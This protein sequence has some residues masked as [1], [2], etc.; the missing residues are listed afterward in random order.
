M[1]IR[2][3]DLFVA[4][5]R[6][7]LSTPCRAEATRRR[8]NSMPRR[9]RVKA[10][11]RL[12]K[13][14]CLLA[15][16]LLS[17]LNLQPSTFAQG[18]A[19]TYQ[20]QLQNNGSPASGTY[21]LTFSLFNVN[22]GGTAVAGP[23]TNNAVSVTNGLFTVLIDFGPGVFTG[24][25]NW[26]EIGVATNGVSSF[27]TLAPRQ[28]LTPT[29]YA[30][31][32][33]NVNAAGIS[34]TVPNASLSG[35]Y[36]NAVTLNNAGNNFS[37]NGAGLA[38]VNAAAL[39]GL[40]ATNYWQLG[41]NNVAAGQF[42]G[43]TNNQAVEFR[44]G[45]QR[46]LLLV[47][48]TTDAPNIIGGAT[49]NAVDA[50]VQGA[51]IAGGGTT[52][53]FGSSSPN[54]ISSDFSSI[55]G[56]SGNWIQNSANHS[57]IAGGLNN[58]I[59]AN[60][61]DSAIGGGL[62]N[63]IQPNAQFAFIGGGA[64][65]SIQDLSYES[66]LGGGA[67]NTIFSFSSRCFLGGGA[68]N[69]IRAGDSFLGGG[70]ANT[71]QFTADHSFLGGGLFNTNSG[72]YS[73]I[74]GGDYNLAGGSRSFAAGHRAKAVH[75]GT[76]VW[77][78]LTESD[79]Q[80]TGTNQF[81]IRAQGGLQLDN[82]TSQFFGNQ[83]RQMLN[84]YN[85]DYG[86]GV[87]T[88]T[89]YFR[90]DNS[91]PGTGF[92]WYLG[93]SHTDAQTNAGDGSTLMLL[94]N[95][96]LTVNG[97]VTASNFTGNGAGLTGVNASS[98][99]SGTLADARLSS[100]VAL[101]NGTQTFSGTNTFAGLMNFGNTTRQMLNLFTTLYGIGVQGY[102][103]YFRTDPSG[104][105]AWYQ[106]GTHN[107]G[108]NNPGGGKTLMLLDGSGNLIV[109]NNIYAHGVLLTSDRNTKE[110]FAP[111]D[112]C[113]VLDKVA[114]L[115]LSEWNFKGDSNT[116]HIGPM[117]QDF[118]A[119]FKVGED[120]KHIAVVDEGG[121]ALAAIQGLNQKLEETRAENADLKQRLAALEKIVLNQ[122]S[123]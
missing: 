118:K 82:S 58:A 121:V 47:P 19:F 71:I 49:V 6:L 68:G 79:F 35:T 110:N 5:A 23:V 119:A 21:N 57:S 48:S 102:T 116:R 72:P 111:V 32:A 86:I 107:D 113:A 31:Y 16:A 11:Q 81:C 26:L 52:N 17:T 114:E 74:V 37:G 76:F 43:S 55:G 29:P 41:G 95:S 92:A 59:Q 88:Y 8:V 20:G 60:A 51:V 7:A 50:G 108:Q 4:L 87:Q 67:G 69:S 27:T 18:T 28:Q 120:D 2:V 65:N 15:L 83:T 90:A 33:E 44:V 63:L 56:G 39:N 80:S 61:Y 101:L 36:G 96:G 34:G 105:F 54:Q 112:A 45:G 53:V 91:V 9:N 98:L 104:G 73:M 77:G 106:G 40:N 89:L 30:I 94:N 123:N 42:L 100:N 1:K 70:Q 75:N 22:S 3:Q 12:G 115:P 109:T 24:A 38:G 10:G 103:E 13:G 78:D 97:M 122:R 93:G 46:S 66:F 14:A 25:T 64:Y 84:L 62:A 85:A 99:T 117:A